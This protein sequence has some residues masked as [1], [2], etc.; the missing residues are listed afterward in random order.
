MASALAEEWLLTFDKDRDDY[1][2][3]EDFEAI[4]RENP[5]YKADAENLR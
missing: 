1:V 3:L 4:I 5:Y 2:D